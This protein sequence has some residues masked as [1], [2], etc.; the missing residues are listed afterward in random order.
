MR[1]ATEWEPNLACNQW[2]R[3]TNQQKQ[4]DR[5][6][7][8]VLHFIRSRLNFSLL[9]SAIMCLRGSR[10]ATHRPASPLSRDIID[11]SSAEGR[12]PNEDW[13]SSFPC[14]CDLLIIIITLLLLLIHLSFLSQAVRMCAYVLYG[15]SGMKVIRHV[16][17]DIRM[18]I[19][20]DQARQQ[21]ILHFELLLQCNV[22]PI[23]WLYAWR[24]PLWAKRCIEA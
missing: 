5:A 19:L 18:I 11:L 24:S 3:S 9:R 13:A 20:D 15:S 21:M 14:T 23:T 12:V 7:G 10:S 16:G 1:C 22:S 2:R 8:K 4:N 6:Y 17:V